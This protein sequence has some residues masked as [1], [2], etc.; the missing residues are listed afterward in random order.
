M[1]SGTRIGMVLALVAFAVLVVWLSIP[2]SPSI[3]EVCLNFGDEMVCRRGAAHTA[4]DA[5]RAAQESVCGGNV[6]GM[7]EL[8]NCRNA[9]PVRSRCWQR[10]EDPPPFAPVNPRPEGPQVPAHQFP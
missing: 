5:A 1:K 8:I 9:P 10:G 7:T 6:R 2:R 3:C 4:E